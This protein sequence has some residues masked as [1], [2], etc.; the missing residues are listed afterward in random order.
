MKAAYGVGSGLRIQLFASSSS[1]IASILVTLF[2]LR[3]VPVVFNHFST[4][5]QGSLDL[6]APLGK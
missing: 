1:A 2:Q 6:P 3:A 5:D 4:F